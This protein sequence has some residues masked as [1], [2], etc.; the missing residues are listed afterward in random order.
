MT[1]R[2]R[3]SREVRERAVAFVVQVRLADHREPGVAGAYAVVAV[4][5]HELGAAGHI[6]STLE[7]PALPSASC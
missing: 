1:L 3:Y 7:S 2:A 6:S 4:Q 5:L